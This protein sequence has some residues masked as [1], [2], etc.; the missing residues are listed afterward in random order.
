MTHCNLSAVLK[1]HKKKYEPAVEQDANFRN[2]LHVTS[3]AHFLSDTLQNMW[4]VHNV[5]VFF[6]Y[7]CLSLMLLGCFLNDFGMVP[8]AMMAAITVPFTFHTRCIATVKYLHLKTFSTPFFY[9]ISI[10]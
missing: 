5:T 2:Y 9:R 4:S 3:H 1:N 6:S 8:G 7:L 10:S